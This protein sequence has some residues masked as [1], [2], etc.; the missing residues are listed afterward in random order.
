[1]NF[2]YLPGPFWFQ[3]S[4]DHFNRA[5]EGTVQMRPYRFLPLVRSD[6]Q[7]RRG[8]DISRVIDHYVERAVAP[9][10]GI[11]HALDVSVTPDVE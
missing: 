7:Q 11:G 10:D 1:M 8:R 9:A 3:E 2:H 6:L 4:P 5:I